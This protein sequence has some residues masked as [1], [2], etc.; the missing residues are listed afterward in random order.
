M[1]QAR[2]KTGIYRALLDLGYALQEELGKESAE[3]DM[4]HDLATKL[5][6]ATG[7]LK[8]PQGEKR[9]VGNLA[10]STDEKRRDDGGENVGGSRDDQLAQEKTPHFVIEV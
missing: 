9:V 5:S 7:G 3:N 4:E 2:C 10:T 6:K 8:V 1:V